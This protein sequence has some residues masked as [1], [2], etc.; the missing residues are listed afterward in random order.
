[1]AKRPL[2]TAAAIMFFCWLK[3]PAATF[4]PMLPDESL[5][6]SARFALLVVEKFSA[7][8]PVWY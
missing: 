1:M 4:T 2:D 5:A 6:E 7:V 3:S 8:L